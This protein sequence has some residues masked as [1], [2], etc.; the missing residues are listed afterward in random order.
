MIGLVSLIAATAI[1]PPP[2]HPKQETI[3]ACELFHNE[4]EAS[5]GWVHQ[6]DLRIVERTDGTWTIEGANRV[7]TVA[8]AFP[9]QFGSVGRSL[10]LRWKD[11]SG[12]EKTAYIS[13]TDIAL[14]NGMK[15]F[16]FSFDRPSHWKTPGYGCQSDGD[17]AAGA[18]S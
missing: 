8:T 11:T 9:A 1:D 15:Y 16:W 3:F 6:V 13:F 5:D 10:G 18:G 14:P 2:V 17:R 4:R 12:V 7:P